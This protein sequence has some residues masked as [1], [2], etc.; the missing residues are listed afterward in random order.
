MRLLISLLLL[1]LTAACHAEK[2]STHTCSLTSDTLNFV[3]PTSDSIAN[4]FWQKDVDGYESINRL[5]IMYKDGSVAVVEHKYCLMY[6]VEIAYYASTANE[7]S[8]SKK[9]SEALKSFFN[10]SAVQ[11]TSIQ[12]AV[13]AIIKRFEEKGFDADSALATAHD[14]STQDN[15]R[16][17]YSVSYMPIEDSSLHRAA[18]FIYIGIG[19]E[20]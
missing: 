8:D 2:G 9:L 10:Y 18:L 17:E 7:L 16:A 19:G 15:K 4:T 20:H 6:N 11:D 5:H 14:D 3:T 12:N 13:S 1:T